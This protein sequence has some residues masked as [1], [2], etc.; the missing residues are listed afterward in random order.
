MEGSGNQ[1]R[2]VLPPDQG[3]LRFPPLGYFCFFSFLCS[4]EVLAGAHS[5]LRTC[6]ADGNGGLDLEE[7]QAWM[8][9]LEANNISDADWAVNDKKESCSALQPGAATNGHWGPRD[10]TPSGRWVRHSLRQHAARNG[11]P[12]IRIRPRNST[13]ETGNETGGDDEDEEDP[14]PIHLDSGRGLY[15]SSEGAM[16][17]CGV[18]AMLVLGLCIFL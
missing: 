15:E 10:L 13:N 5:H 8:E 11:N 9:F 6:E 16:T 12:L 14:D 18:L 7:A 4:S 3:S 1:P 17:R 2:D